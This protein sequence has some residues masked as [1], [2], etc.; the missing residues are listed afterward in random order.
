MAA[1]WPISEQMQGITHP[2]LG[3]FPYLCTG[4][5]DTEPCTGRLLREK[6]LRHRTGM[7][8]LFHKK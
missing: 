6:C 4:C 3:L 2:A 8:I 5:D 1:L 7:E